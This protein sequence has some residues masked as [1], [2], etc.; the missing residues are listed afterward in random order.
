MT[1]AHTEGQERY[2][3]LSQKI[4]KL[5]NSPGWLLDALLKRPSQRG[6]KSL[7]LERLEERA[8]FSAGGLV[9]LVSPVWFQN[10][11]SGVAGRNS[12]AGYLAASTAE[13]NAGAAAGKN[14]SIAD[15]ANTYDWIVRFS[16]QAIAGISSV[17]QTSSLLAGSGIDFSVVRGLG[18]VGQVLVQSAGASL[19]TVE[20]YF[21]TNTAVAH[22]D[23]DV[24]RTFNALPNDPQLGQLWGLNNTGQ[25]GGT[26]HADINAPAAW[27]ISTGSRNVVVAVID[28]GVDYTHSDLAANIWTN[29]RETAG[30]GR[31]DDGDG[32]ADDVH[33]YD[34]VN[35][36]GDP[37]DDFG[38]GTHVAGTIGGVGN[39]GL[40]VAGVNWSVSIM[41]LKFLGA[42]GSG[43]T[44]DAVRAIN[45]ATMQRTRY[46]V[47]VRVLNCSWGGGGFDSALQDAIQA[48]GNAGILTVA[49]AGN[50]GRN[51]DVY[52]NYPSNYG[53]SSLLAVA[54]TDRNDNLASFS[55]YGAASVDLAA[56]G[57]SVYSTV[58]GNGYAIYS[59]TSM[60]T[61][62]VAGVAALA[63]SVA[64]SASVS[65]IRNAILQG[66]DR[67][68][69]LSGKVATGGR[70]DAYNTLQL[71]SGGAP[72][73][74]VIASLTASPNPATAGAA[75]TLAAHGIADPGG[76]VTGIS[77][78]QDTNGNNQWDVNDRLLGST[79]TIASGEASLAIGTSFA[80]GNYTFFARAADNHSQWSGA[81]GTSLQ[82]L[83]RDDHGNDPTSATRVALPGSVAGTIG[84]GG[85][86]DYFSFDAVAGRSYSFQTQL[87][88][89]PD[90]VLSLYDRD[91]TTRIG[92][93]DDWGSTL[94]SK[95]V[96]TAPANGTYYLEVAA[97]NSTQTGSYTL[98]LSSENGAP[99]FARI[100]D[101]TM[102]RRERS[103]SIT[104]QATDPNGDALTYSAQ[105]LTANTGAA[106]SV[107]GNVLTIT[108]RSGF[109][110]TFAVQATVSDGVARVSQTFQVSVTNSAPVLAR[111]AD[112]T[113]SRNERSRSITLQASDADGD[114]LTYSAQILTAKTGATASVSGNVL[115]IAPRAG[116]LGNFSVR[117]TVSDGITS[118][119]QTFQVSVSNRAPL[120]AR[121][122][123]QTMSRSERS[124]AITLQVSDA[125]GDALKFSAQVLKYDPLAK[126]AYDLDQQ[127]GLSKAGNYF[128]NL[129]H[130]NEKWMQGNRGAWYCILPNG[131]V[132]AWAG[133]MAA[134]PV[135]ATLSSAYY[136]N[137]AL[138]H[139]ARP[140]ALTPTNDAT[141]TVSG[142]VLTVTPRSGLLGNFYVQLTVSDG[143]TSTSQTFQVS[144][145]NSTASRA[146]MASF[147]ADTH[148][149]PE[150]SPA[151]AVQTPPH[152]ILDH[153]AAQG[154]LL[155]RAVADRIQAAGRSAANRQA[156][157][158]SH[159]L[160]GRLDALTAAIRELTAAPCVR[161]TLVAADSQPATQWHSNWV[162][163][164]NAASS[165]DLQ[166]NAEY[167]ARHEVERQVLDAVFALADEYDALHLRGIGER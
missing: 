56:P 166:D 94:A 76:T 44:S 57:V 77:F 161:S 9:D 18:L 70:L 144:V 123:D 58:P 4:C 96:W 97:Y 60:A 11:S 75:I 39:N 73:L 158:A 151:R 124:R 78:Y 104:L 8:L 121:I 20:N 65:D 48:A 108:P 69:G 134:S 31:D 62:H 150:Q 95:I 164:W 106:V 131:Q 23:L 59:G 126:L 33:G 79:S 148:G 63:W 91:G 88:T 49:A 7:R 89:L 41:P 64:P 86:V 137:P 162:S 133:S 61:P 38:H 141:A 43:R 159:W 34:F 119:S 3:G 153:L 36:D 45:Y 55:N 132:R 50:D 117:V 122:A 140:P 103:R 112:Q 100:G 12:A 167:W 67:I 28:T 81:A 147:Q 30:N 6:G 142:N 14:L 139:D 110:G 107:S 42:N 5:A 156:A 90:S 1:E 40:G 118:A 145:T 87:Q 138:L 54:A 22:Y 68:A 130:A 53:S 15:S 135:V 152:Q 146:S 72:Q 92:W 98:S 113:M 26:P 27:G 19:E 109:L 71:L 13:Q 46:G 85:D 120:Q 136:N 32:F 21:S 82:V 111:I 10:V 16:T 35:N 127:L 143:T 155:E 52:P 160:Q 37:T 84:T 24:V 17:A 115:K 83:A 149:T 2:P 66:A 74:P 93:N 25:N 129:Y 29:L 154:A 102:S 125:D 116:F 80:A 101:Q 165:V 47:N 128:Q 51:N 99:V 105:V 163:V 114:R 157:L